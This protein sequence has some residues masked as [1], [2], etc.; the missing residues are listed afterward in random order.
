MIP[1]APGMQARRT[2]AR[3]N[4]S[5]TTP[6]WG[7]MARSMSASGSGSGA[8]GRRR[9]GVDECRAAS[10]RRVG[11]AHPEAVHPQRVADLLLHEARKRSCLR[12]SAP[13]QFAD[14][15]AKGI[16]V[17]TGL[18][19]RFPKVARERRW[20]PP[21]HPTRTCPRRLP[22]PASVA[23]R[24][25]ASAHRGRSPRPSRGLR[26]PASRSRIGAVYSI[27]PR[28]AWTCSAVAATAFVAEKTVQIVSAVIGR[29]S[30]GSASPR[31]NVD[32]EFAVEI[33]N[34]LQPQ[35][36]P[37][38]NS[39]LNDGAHRVRWV[40]HYFLRSTRGVRVR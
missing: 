20:I 15:P 33:G 27:S 39:L 28:S 19:P 6:I 14:D 9:R 36:G 25:G 32:H 37:S 13:H 12:I 8:S 7:G 31:P 10:F 3:P 40:C 34:H 22:L 18:L 30:S 21:C 29:W 23:R 2:S 26:T 24:S 11:D 1:P 4:T 35:L 5:C 16:C 17:V 38:C